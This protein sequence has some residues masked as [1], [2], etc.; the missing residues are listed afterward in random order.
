MH[1]KRKRSRSKTKEAVVPPQPVIRSSLERFVYATERS[2]HG[3][4]GLTGLPLAIEAFHTLGLGEVCARELQL[5]ERDRGPTEAQWVE[6]LTMLH[7]AGGTS[8][9]DLRI[10]KQDDGLCRL[11]NVPTMVSARSALDFLKRFHDPD[12]EM[13]QPGKAVIV[14][15]TEG[16]SGLGR[17]NAHLLAQVQKHHPVD[18]ATLDLDASIH[19]CNKREALVAYEH[20]RAYQPVIV[21]WSEQKLVVH[22]EFR[23]G[24]VPAGMGNVGVLEAALKALPEGISKKYVRGDSALYEHRTLR[25]LDREG[26]EFAI[27]ADL[28]S[29][30]RKEIEALPKKAWNALPPREGCV[31]K[32]ERFWAEVPFVPDDR[33]ARKGERPFRYIAIK[34][35]PKAV[36][37][38]LFE[39]APPERYVAIVTNRDLPGDELIHWHREKCGTVEKMHDLLKH[40][41]GA[42]LFPSGVFGANAAWYRLAALALNLYVAMTHL[43]LPPEC[44]DERLSTARFRFFNRAGRVIR[45]ARRFLVVLSHV[46]VPLA[47]TYIDV[48]EALSALT[49]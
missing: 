46:A 9:E 28:T 47:A 16:L 27:S 30:L 20:G 37:L 19:P 36:Q 13:S 1:P 12:L 15:Q 21:V 43:S 17:V 33:A 22:D 29:E 41:V 6:V 24:N 39:P 25:F 3:V 14:P 35:P 7:L 42:R 48:R 4:T 44:K 34:L 10:F 49:G 26:I 5:K 38:D 2:D 40:D 31:A 45:H 18:V 8:L 11:W 23:D 32:E